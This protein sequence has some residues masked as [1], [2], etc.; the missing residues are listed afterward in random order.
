MTT[1]CPVRCIVALIPAHGLCP[2]GYSKL[3]FLRL[4]GKC[5]GQAEQRGDDVPAAT[6]VYTLHLSH[7]LA[8]LDREGHRRY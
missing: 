2:G 8:H 3:Q 5:A 6:P 7:A 4:L 1:R